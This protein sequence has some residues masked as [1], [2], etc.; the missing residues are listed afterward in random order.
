MQHKPI[1]PLEKT[2]A[3]VGRDRATPKWSFG[4]RGPLPAKLTATRKKPTGKRTIWLWLTLFGLAGLGGW[5]LLRHYQQAVAAAEFQRQSF[6]PLDEDYEAAKKGSLCVLPAVGEAAAADEQQ[7]VLDVR[8]DQEKLQPKPPAPRGKRPVIDLDQLVYFEKMTR[9][10]VRV[11]FADGSCRL[12]KFRDLLRHIQAQQSCDFFQPVPR[13]GV[14]TEYVN[15][16]YIESFEKVRCGSED[17]YRA[18]LTL[19]TDD[20]G[21]CATWRVIR[22]SGVGLFSRYVYRKLRN[23]MEQLNPHVDYRYSRVV[24]AEGC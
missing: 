15:L 11:L 21:S 4:K 12:F 16:H 17:R 24:P 8:P 5:F 23:R 6:M 2:Q 20:Q 22:E 9:K 19:V 10:Q 13:N 7:A 18:K 3:F 14:S 1:Q